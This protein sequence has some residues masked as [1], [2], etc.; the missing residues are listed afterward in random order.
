[1]AKFNSLKDIQIKQAKPKEK[2]YYLFDGLGLY[3]EVTPNNSKI[4]KFRYT[5][6]NKRKLTSFRSYPKVSLSQARERRDKYNELIIKNIDPIQYY[7]EEKIV[8]DIED[9]STFK[10]IFYE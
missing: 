9:K 3:L 8:K 7:K 5:F 4:W 6:N 1:M 10:N 2:P